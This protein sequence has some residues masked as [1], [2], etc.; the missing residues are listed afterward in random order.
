[1]HKMRSHVSFEPAN[2]PWSKMCFKPGFLFVS[3]Y[4]DFPT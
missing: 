3:L 1:M 4:A 2:I